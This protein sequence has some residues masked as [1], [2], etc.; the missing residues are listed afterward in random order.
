MFL[1][2]TR[3]HTVGIDVALWKTDRSLCKRMKKKLFSTFMKNEGKVGRQNRNRLNRITHPNL[4]Y[5]ERIREMCPH[6][7]LPWC[8]L[9][10]LLLLGDVLPPSASGSRA[11]ASPG[12]SHTSQGQPALPLT[13][14]LCCW[15]RSTASASASF[16]ALMRASSIKDIKGTRLQKE[17]LGDTNMPK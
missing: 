5:G 4:G 3:C 7:A 9:L 17:I 12:R 2:I 15:K 11:P 6:P 1:K 13:H 16:N 8:R 14:A 10:P